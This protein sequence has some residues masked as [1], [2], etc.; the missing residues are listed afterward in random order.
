GVGG[1]TDGRD[2]ALGGD[3][4]QQDRVDTTVHQ[5]V[6]EGALLPGVALGVGLVDA[7]FLAGLGSAVLDPLADTA[8]EALR[9]QV[10][11]ADCEGLGGARGASAL[12]VA[13]CAEAE[14]KRER[15]TDRCT[16]L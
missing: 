11:G 16:S 6:E 3:R 12:A 13:A 9:V 15:E 1:G 7:D 14:G 8:V 10:D 5:G 2:R 4:R